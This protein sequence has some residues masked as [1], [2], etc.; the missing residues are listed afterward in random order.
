MEDIG[1]KKVMIMLAIAALLVTV[2]GPAQAAM[3]WY[4]VTI[5]YAG[6][7]TT[8]ANVVYVNVTSQDGSWSGAKWYIAT[9]TEA[10]ACLA[11]ALSAWSMGAPVMLVLDDTDLDDWSPM[12]GI[13]AAPAQ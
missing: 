8:P 13:F 1:M 11:T 6:V 7:N 5:N 2:A 9:G 10:K 4:S 3:K 12:Y